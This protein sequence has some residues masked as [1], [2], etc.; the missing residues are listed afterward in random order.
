LLKLLGVGAFADQDLLARFGLGSA[1]GLQCWKCGAAL[2]VLLELH[3]PGFVPAA[4]GAGAGGLVRF[5]S[6][7]R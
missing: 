7:E 6:T 5:R 1:E 2:L 4:Q 3:A